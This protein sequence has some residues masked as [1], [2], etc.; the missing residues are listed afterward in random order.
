MFTEILGSK[1]SFSHGFSGVV[2]E[3]MLCRTGLENI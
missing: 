1:L 3:N 2:T